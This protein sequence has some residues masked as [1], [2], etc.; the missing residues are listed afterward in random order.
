MQIDMNDIHKAFGK[1]QVLSG[2]SFNLKPGEVHA[3]M[4]EN[5]AGKS[6][7]MNLLTGLQ[8]LDKGSIRINGKETYFSNPKEA[9]QNG[10]AFIHQE[11]NIWPEMTV[12]ENLFIGKE[13]TSKLGI[14]NT[15]KMKALAKKQFEKLSVSLSLDQEAGKCSVGQQQM[16]EIAKALM[17]KAE[18][19][20]MDEPTAAL[21]EREI[22]KLFEVIASLKK[23]GVSIVYISHRMEEIFSICDRITIMRDGKTVDTANISETSFDEVVKKMVGREL[24]DRYPQRRPE[25]GD[26]VLEVRDASKK[27]SFEHVSF[28]VRS[29]E[30]VGVSGLMGAG[31]TEI[32]RA[33]F[34]IDRLD[35]GEIWLAGKKTNIK[36]P[37]DAVKKGLGFITENRKD[38]GLLLDTSIRE[39]IALPSLTSF[40]PKGVIDQ[41]REASFVELLINRLTIK[42]ASPE[43]HAR[44]LSG[45]NQ[46]KV[47]IA[48]WIGIGPKVLILDEPTRGVDVGAKR[49]IYTLMNELTD[50]GVAIIMVS[51]ELPEIIGMSDRI[52][53]VHEGKIS[54]EV[55][56]RE[57]TQERIMTLATGGQ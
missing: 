13:M 40:S 3:L 45:G 10:I 39:N 43:T 8:G 24:T 33:L 21:T 37:N 1:N 9:E 28:H 30:I 34:G 54:G 26:I 29:G 32:M 2:V 56:S 18:V 38:E 20:I 25:L 42:T 36:N 44:N 7:L 17:T 48:K 55:A 5:G 46:Q 11:L 23:D 57:A 12:L 15:K 6:T 31:R 41:K 51:S 4:G 19:I 22:N 27:G 53:V 52:I 16:I 47:V 35:S 50:R 49:E 14:L